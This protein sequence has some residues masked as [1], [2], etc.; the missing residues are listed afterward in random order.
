MMCFFSPRQFQICLV[1]FFLNTVEAAKFPCKLDHYCFFS[2]PISNQQE[3]N[4]RLL[5]I[6]F[7]WIFLTNHLE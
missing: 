4:P 6:S 1:F 2:F 7:I 5:Y 3:I